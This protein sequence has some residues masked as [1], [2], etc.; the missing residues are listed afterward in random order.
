MLGGIGPLHPSP[1]SPSRIMNAGPSNSPFP[2]V[3]PLQHQGPVGTSSSIV[4]GVNPIG[5]LGRM[6][7][8]PSIDKTRLPQDY[9]LFPEISPHV[10]KEIEDEANSYFQRIYNHP[11]H[12]TL[13]IDEVLLMLKRFQDSHNKREKEVF[14][15]MLRNLFEEYKFFPQYPDKELLITAQLF[16]G[17]IER[18][19]VGSYV[20]LGL[21]L[22]FVLEALKKPEGSKMYYFGVAA[23]DK[24]KNRLKEYHKYCEHVRAIPHFSEFPPHL[25]DYVEFGLQGMEPPSKPEGPVLPASLA[26]MVAPQNTPVSQVYKPN[27]VTSGVSSKSSTTSSNTLGSRPSIANTTNIDTLLVA[28]EKEEKPVAPP[29][30]LQDKTAF[31][32]NNL[33]QLNLKSK[34]DE[35]RELVTDEY[36]PW[37]AQYLVMKRASIEVNFHVLYSHFLD[38]LNINEIYRMVTK[39]TYRNIKVLLRSDKAI[40]NFSDRSLLKNLGHWLGMLTLARNKP[41]LQIDIDLKS[42]LVEAY[43]KGQQEL[44]YV[45]PF[46]AKVLE[47]CAKSK[48]FKPPNPWTMAIMNVLAELHQEPDLKLTLKFEIEVLCKNLEIEVGQLK[49]SC[50]LKDP[51]R[52]R[53]IEYQ[54]S[55]PTKKEPAAITSSTQNSSGQTSSLNEPELANII[56]GQ[57]TSSP[58][59]QNN[60]TTPTSILPTPPEPRFT[61]SDIQIAG[62]AAFQQHTTISPTILLFQTQPQLKPLVRTSIEHAVQEWIAP[63]VDR[64]IKIALQTCEQVIRK[65]FALDPDEN[66]MRI[67]AHCMVRNLAAGMAM[68]TCRDQLLSAINTRLKQALIASIGTPTLQQ[69]EM[70]EQAASVIANENMELACAFVQ[71]TAVEKAIPEIDKRLMSEYE[72]RKIARNEGR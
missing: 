7:P 36:Y 21:A 37:L 33:S 4:L 1:G 58:V 61:Y 20:T 60:S 15:C 6:G 66:R 16:G 40:A 17:I 26:P 69:K 5:S 53:K 56:P 71:K 38:T 59:T 47:S 44:L 32:F 65:D 24:F 43:H 27:S 67:A 72:L 13:T 62:M 2:P 63:V 29:E 11:P 25:Q 31:I 9:N 48:V 52:I 41:I 3:I 34:C 68:I 42:L 39:E 19:I 51:E 70:I 57:T 54:L 30:T 50:Y 10:S 22:R 28:T 64:S 46:V 49:P 18:G 55:Q 8:N 23:L 45:V 12:P 14:N 35:L